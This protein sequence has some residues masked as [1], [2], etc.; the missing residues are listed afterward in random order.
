VF[1]IPSPLRSQAARST[2][3]AGGGTLASMNAIRLDGDK[4]FLS[5]GWIVI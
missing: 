1:N 3:L 5:K 4:V 2:Y